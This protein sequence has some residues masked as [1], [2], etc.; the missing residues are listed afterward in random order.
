[1]NK[2]DILTENNGIL[3][4]DYEYIAFDVFDTILHRFVMPK[5]I[6][7][8]WAFEI[9]QNALVKDTDTSLLFKRRFAGWVAKLVNVLA[10]YDKECEYR[11][12]I[13]MLYL[14]ISS[15]L[16]YREFYQ[17]A[18]EL[19]MSVEKELTYI[20]ETMKE[21]IGEALKKSKSVIC[22]SDYALPGES[23]K[24]ILKY[25]GVEAEKVY[26]SSD[27]KMLKSTGRLYKYV[28]DEIDLNPDRILMIG[29]NYQSDFLMAKTVG[30]KAIQLGDS[31]RGAGA[32]H[33]SKAAGM[34]Y[35]FTERLH[36]QLSKQRCKT[37]LFLSREGIFLKKLF[38]VYQNYYL[39]KHPGEVG[40]E[41]EL[42][43]CSRQA[44]LMPSVFD[45][46]KQS[47]SEIY[48][49]YS[50]IRVSDFLRNINMLGDEEI[51]EE[52]IDLLRE[53]RLIEDFENSVE[54]KTILDSDLFIRKCIQKA[55]SQRSYLISYISTLVPNY[56]TEG[57]YIVDVG[58][59]GTCSRL[60]SKAL[61]RMV[62]IH[63]YYMIS[64]VSDESDIDCEKFK[65]LLYDASRDKG[66]NVYAYNEMMIEM[67][68]SAGCG[69]IIEYCC[70]EGE[71]KPVFSNESIQCYDD[72]IKPIQN[73]L[74][75]SFE[76]IMKYLDNHDIHRK[77][78]EEYFEKEYM[79][80][81]LSP[82]KEEMNLYMQI[83][84]KDNFAAFKQ[85]KETTHQ[86]EHKE[87]SFLSFFK[88]IVS[89]GL[90]IRDQET[91][92]IAVALYK[93]NLN[94]FNKL[95]RRFPK[96]AFSLYNRYIKKKNIL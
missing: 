61:K 63:T 32:H 18:L 10:G 74:C 3:D 7:R 27:K 9:T 56:E 92:W 37:V 67:L 89:G 1:M 93:M 54:Y 52:F 16:S 38:D 82:S 5:D 25:H 26:S 19:E 48:R 13:S 4:E 68:L 23:E 22:I 11:Q 17:Y 12:L 47:F 71:I 21:L 75:I 70:D 42:F 39:E 69:S 85:Y 59:H 14:M 46:T 2:F 76:R 60:I 64:R 78:Y 31:I 33:F 81:I 35:V 77:H 28:A 66:L 84:V 8:L 87:F 24:E 55:N 88:L 91:N 41:S 95:M 45:V 65:G 49:N 86:N 30:L 34:L 90:L 43:Y 57:L 53:D 29:D 44:A 94:L 50:S 51:Q 73:N 83:P 62:P 80:L 36:R 58:Y 6:L 15:S 20:P 72:I 40:I 79:D 96:M